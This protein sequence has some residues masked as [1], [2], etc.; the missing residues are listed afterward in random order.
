[1]VPGF[2]RKLYNNGHFEGHS[3]ICVQLAESLIFTLGVDIS[4]DFNAICY[5]HGSCH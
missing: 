5:V 1:M 2:V 3:G 4:S